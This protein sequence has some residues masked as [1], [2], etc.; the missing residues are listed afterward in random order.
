MEG[1]YLRDAS[2]CL[3][4]GSR[5]SMVEWEAVIIA[6]IESYDSNQMNGG[7]G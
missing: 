2:R 5:V 4:K 3:G 1:R 7:K 6:G